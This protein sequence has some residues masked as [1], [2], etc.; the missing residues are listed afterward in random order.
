MKV[1]ILRLI[2]CETP[3]NTSFSTIAQAYSFT[4]PREA[5]AIP[6]RS[7]DKSVIKKLENNAKIDP[8][9]RAH[10]N[11]LFTMSDNVSLKLIAYHHNVV[12]LRYSAEKFNGTCYN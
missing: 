11:T 6:R 7:R 4:F 2:H 3:E 1:E 8:F 5:R 10:T 9:Q 12:L